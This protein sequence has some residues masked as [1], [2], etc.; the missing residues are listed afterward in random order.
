MFRRGGVRRYHRS[1]GALLLVVT[2]LICAEPAD[3]NHD[4]TGPVKSVICAGTDAAL[5][6]WGVTFGPGVGGANQVIGDEKP[7]P[8]VGYGTAIASD[9]LGSGCGTSILG[10]GTSG[11][12]GVAYGTVKCLT[13]YTGTDSFTWYDG[14]GDPIG[15][16]TGSTGDSSTRTYID[17][18]TTQAGVPGTRRV[19]FCVDVTFVGGGS[20]SKCVLS[21]RPGGGGI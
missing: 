13:R 14:A 10:L 12:S 8:I 4:C 19:Q 21:S 1:M 18:S 3:A 2:G 9:W 16:S 5:G 17:G 7:N 6:A 20:Y 11:P 15:T